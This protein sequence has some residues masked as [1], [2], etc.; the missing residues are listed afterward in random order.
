LG[1][2]RED[3]YVEKDSFR[4]S[5]RCRH[6]YHFLR[7]TDDRGRRLVLRPAKLR[8]KVRIGGHSTAM[9]LEL[10]FD[11]AFE[12]CL[13]YDA[14]VRDGDAS[15]PVKQHC[16]R[17]F[18]GLKSPAAVV[19]ANCHRILHKRDFSDMSIPALS[20]DRFHAGLN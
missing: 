3:V 8:A 4:K 2:V 12:R 14:D 11:V 7:S 1:L 20:C 15:F 18:V 5:A 17:R 10:Y 13:V 16:F 9:L 19:N 6:L